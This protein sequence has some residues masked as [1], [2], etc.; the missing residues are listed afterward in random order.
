ME[1]E[2]QQE[3]YTISD[4]VTAKGWEMAGSANFQPNNALNVSFSVT[5]PGELSET[6]GS[7]NYY[8]D[9][10]TNMLNV[11][12]SVSESLKSDFITYIDTV[13]D[14]ISTHFEK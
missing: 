5:K 13:I 10:E 1:I 11:S 6:I 14:S 4:K 2:K 8:K 9:G 12:Y 7:C 3:M